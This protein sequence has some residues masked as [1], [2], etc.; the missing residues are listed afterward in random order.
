MPPQPPQVDTNH[1]ALMSQLDIF[2]TDRPWKNPNWKPSNRR[3]KSVK[4][5]L[6]EISRK[7]QASL[8][9]AKAAAEELEDDGDGDIKMTDDSTKSVVPVMP[10]APTVTYSNIEA[11]P[12]MHP[13]S[14]RPYCDVTGLPAPYTDPKSGLR[15]HNKEVYAFISLFGQEQADRY[16]ATRNANFTLK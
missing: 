3:N 13:S 8:Q 15:Y 4:H 1:L 12:S 14:R 16:L 9:A 10:P 7:E 2:G 6:S 5:I 11:A